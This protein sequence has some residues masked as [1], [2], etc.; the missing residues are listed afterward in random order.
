MGIGGV[1]LVTRN[2]E[3]KL[4]EEDNQTDQYQ[5]EEEDNVVYNSLEEYK[6]AN[7]DSLLE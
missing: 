3:K 6:D 7:G 1:A 5:E 2:K 4:M